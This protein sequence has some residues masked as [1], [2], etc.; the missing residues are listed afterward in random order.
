MKKKLATRDFYDC[1]DYYYYKFVLWLWQSSMLENEFK[2]GT[3]CCFPSY[4]F[5]D[6]TR[7][8]SLLNLIRKQAHG[9]K[10]IKPAS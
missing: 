7:L 10:I 9:K 4:F 8:D 3:R 2:D 5:L 1:R 6:S